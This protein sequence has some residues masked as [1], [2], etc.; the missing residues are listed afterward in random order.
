MMGYFFTND[1][2]VYAMPA[3][4]LKIIA[5]TLSGKNS[6]T[7][8]ADPDFAK[9]LARNKVSEKSVILSYTNL[10]KYLENMLSMFGMFTQPGMMF[11]IEDDAGDEHESYGPKTREDEFAKLMKEMPKWNTFKKYFIGCKAIYQV[12]P[13]PD[14][15]MWRSFTQMG[16]E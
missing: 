6:S 1:L 7:L 15:I 4:N 8:A 2:F 13:T 12:Y 5:D 11:D 16:S 9:L 3:S 10:E 14:G